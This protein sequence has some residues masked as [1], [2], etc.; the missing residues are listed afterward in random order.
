MSNLRAASNKVTAKICTFKTALKNGLEYD[1]LKAEHAEDYGWVFHNPELADLLVQY[2][3]V[4]TEADAAMDNEPGT[5]G[6][7]LFDGDTESLY[8][9]S[10]RCSCGCTFASLY[11][12][13][14]GSAM[15]TIT[16]PDCRSSTEEVDDSVQWNR[17][18]KAWR[19]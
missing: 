17:A 8:F 7:V 15:S 13:D 12:M 9:A 6:T 18:T 2:H 5:E 14:D 4:V 3:F 10:A 1:R 19:K 16:C 11:M